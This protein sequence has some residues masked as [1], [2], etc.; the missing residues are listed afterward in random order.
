MFRPPLVARARVEPD[1]TRAETRFRLSPK[2]TSPFESAG[3]Q[4]SRLLAAEMCTSALVML[5]TPRPEAVWEYWLPTSFASFSF[6]S[7]PVHH[8]VP[9]HSERSILDQH[10]APPN[11]TLR[12][13][14]LNEVP[15]GHKDGHRSLYAYCVQN[16][17]SCELYWKR[18]AVTE[19]QYHHIAI[20]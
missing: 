15:S 16:I 18:L 2:R 6:T 9:P 17:D 7:P 5:D 10:T 13:L 3:S 20:L 11:T 8:R 1:G 4:F 14:H 19:F 12:T